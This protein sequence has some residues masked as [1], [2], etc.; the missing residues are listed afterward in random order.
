MGFAVTTLERVWDEIQSQ[1]NWDMQLLHI[2]LL[3]FR[4]YGCFFFTLLP[5]LPHFFKRLGSLKRALRLNSRLINCITL[6]PL[7]AQR[8]ITLKWHTVGA[9][10]SSCCGGK[11]AHWPT[12]LPRGCRLRLSRISIIVNIF[13]SLQFL[14]QKEYRPLKPQL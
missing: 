9:G 3:F 12:Q 11:C 13:F 8:Q 4:R 10:L 7:D 1:F 6:E 5:F 14:W 2:T